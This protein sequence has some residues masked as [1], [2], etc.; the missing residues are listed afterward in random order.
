MN[1]RGG[2][3]LIEVSITLAALLVMFTFCINLALRSAKTELL[4]ALQL[5]Q[6]ELICLQQQA[7]ACNATYRIKFLPELNAYQIIQSERIIQH[8]LPRSTVFGFISGIK[9]PPSKP[10]TL[11]KQPI[12][13]EN[14]Y[15]LAAIIQPHGRISSGTV[16]LMHTSGTLMGALTITPHQVAH[17]R[18][19]L[20]ENKRSWNLL[21]M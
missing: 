2:Y 21:A 14:P 20:L 8:K 12:K 6:I 11:I 3:T 16:Y 1:N 18:V 4:D 10:E 19:Y 7:I 13:F 9:G 5:L 15:P 17:I